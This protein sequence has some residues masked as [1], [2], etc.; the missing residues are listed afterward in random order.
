MQMNLNQGRSR[1]DLM[2]FIPH[3]LI[4]GMITSSF[5]LGANLSY[6]YIRGRIYV[7]LCSKSHC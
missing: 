6:I 4:E 3:L 7:G 5:A 2:E 1:I